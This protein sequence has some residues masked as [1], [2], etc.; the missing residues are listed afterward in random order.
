METCFPNRSYALTRIGIDTRIV[1]WMF[2][3]SSR[4]RKGSGTMFQFWFQSR[5]VGRDQSI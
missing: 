2:G 1:T 5:I 4:F 3:G